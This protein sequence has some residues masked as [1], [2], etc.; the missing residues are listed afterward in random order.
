M[1]SFKKS[2]RTSTLATSV[3]RAVEKVSLC[4]AS[5]VGGFT[6]FYVD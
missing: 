4:Y 5:R 2:N 6:P 1:K 3:E